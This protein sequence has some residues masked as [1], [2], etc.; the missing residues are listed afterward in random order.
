MRLRGGFMGCCFAPSAATECEE[1]ENG[2]NGEVKPRV[3]FV[4]GG[5]GSGKGTHCGKMCEEYEGIMHLSAGDLLRAE[6][7]SGSKDG[8][9][10]DQYMKEGKIIPVQL[11]A[12]LLLRAIQSNSDRF[13]L[14]LVDGFPRDMQ[15][16]D[17]WRRI[18][19]PKAE[20]AFMLFLECDKQVMLDRLLQRGKTS[21]RID[22]NRASILKRFEVYES[23]TK[24][25]VGHFESSNKLQRVKS[26]G[27][28]AQVFE[29]V[30]QAFAP[31]RQEMG[32]RKRWRKRLVISGVG[33]VALLGMAAAALK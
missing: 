26:E 23:S 20:V 8:A 29:R 9:M 5:P 24:H 21:G 32:L 14:F 15:N 7:Q 28:K 11:T 19:G 30:R 27:S 10:I 25:V 1:P 17:G 13:H 2:E 18:V 31:L 12:R 22:D 33:A 16:L 6:K 4:L 3:V